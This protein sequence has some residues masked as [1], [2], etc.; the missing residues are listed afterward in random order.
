[1]HL[2]YVDDSKDEKH[3]CFFGKLARGADGKATQTASLQRPEATSG[4]LLYW[5]EMPE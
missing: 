2:V 5:A 3:I 1:M 4:R